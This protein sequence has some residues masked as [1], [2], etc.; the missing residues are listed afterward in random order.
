MPL[1][2][3]ECKTRSKKQTFLQRFRWNE[4]HASL[5]TDGPVDR[6]P[7]CF[8]LDLSRLPHTMVQC[9][10]P[11]VA[12]K[13][14]QGSLR[15]LG[16]K[17]LGKLQGLTG[18][19]K[20]GTARQPQPANRCGKGHI[21]NTTVLYCTKKKKRGAGLDRAWENLHPRPDLAWA[22]VNLLA[23]LKLR[24]LPSGSPASIGAN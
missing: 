3:P 2:S 21:Q 16:E 17:R 14:L 15:S 1:N 6:E 9:S 18:A 20:N 19:T 24:F 4:A 8:P 7:V 12:R 10:I 13:S 23:V 11:L 5:G 22:I